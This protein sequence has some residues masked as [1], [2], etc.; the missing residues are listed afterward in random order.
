MVR[1]YYRR[2]TSYSTVLNSTELDENT[3]V[4]AT[5]TGNEVSQP[6]AELTPLVLSVCRHLD[7]VNKQCSWIITLSVLCHC[8]SLNWEI[9][10]GGR[11]AIH[12]WCFLIDCWVSVVTWNREI[13]SL[14]PHLKYT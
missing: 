10:G 13:W 2:P 5:D 6:T 12:P 4:N 7:K 14:L 9:L 8:S 11:E 1:A 3:S